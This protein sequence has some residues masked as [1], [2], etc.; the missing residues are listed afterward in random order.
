MSGFG[1]G[2][3][4][5]TTIGARARDSK[6]SGVYVARR[7]VVGVITGMSR[8]NIDKVRENILHVR[9]GFVN[10]KKP[11]CAGFRMETGQQ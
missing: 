5:G 1:I 8:F 4:G 10:V 7:S 6:A 11:L 3:A 9:D 2:M